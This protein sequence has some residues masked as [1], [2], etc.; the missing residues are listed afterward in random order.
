MFSNNYNLYSFAEY[1][2][3]FMVSIIWI[4]WLV[5]L[6]YGKMV[7]I[8]FILVLQIL[9][10]SSI[11]TGTLSTGFSGMMLEG[12]SFYNFNGVLFYKNY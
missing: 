8:D 9:F 4:Y 1:G 3:Y 6:F 2:T 12:F 10:L 7:V 5:G 11:T